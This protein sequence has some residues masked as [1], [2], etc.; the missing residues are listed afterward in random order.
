MN[1]RFLLVLAA[2]LVAGTGTKRKRKESKKKSTETLGTSKKAKTGFFLRHDPWVKRP[3]K[4]R[5]VLDLK[6]WDSTATEKI[7]TR[8]CQFIART[9]TGPY[10]KLDITDEKRWSGTKRF[11]TNTLRLDPEWVRF[12]HLAGSTDLHAAE[13]ACSLYA[14][15][16]ENLFTW[17]DGTNS[18]DN[19]R[20]NKIKAMDD[21]RL[22]TQQDMT[23]KMLRINKSK[24]KR[25]GQGRWPEQ[26][27]MNHAAAHVEIQIWNGGVREWATVPGAWVIP[28]SYEANTHSPTWKWQKLRKDLT[29]K[30]S[31]TAI[32]LRFEAG[33]LQRQPQRKSYWKEQR[34]LYGRQFQSF[35]P[36]S[37]D[38]VYPFYR[39]RNY[40]IA[41]SPPWQDFAADSEFS[42]GSIVMAWSF[43]GGIYSEIQKRVNKN[44]L[45]FR[46]Y[47]SCQ[48][49]VGDTLNNQ[50]LI[51][52]IVPRFQLKAQTAARIPSE[53]YPENY[54]TNLAVWYRRWDGKTGDCTTQSEL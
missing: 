27:A 51:E 11:T 48:F 54:D 25:Y 36:G 50:K 4:N 24:K 7:G 40:V 45:E 18:R 2:V 26:L 23:S 35:V 37:T 33:L 6:N 20:P 30:H 39:D 31:V 22:C 19:T 49:I 8:T 14:G 41:Y 34:K 5:F 47:G 13:R 42:P 53:N 16:N 38:S 15:N 9:D 52:M 29:A 17:N 44:K 3:W 32:Q 1:R 28:T 10:G 46:I 12:R 21:A 43:L